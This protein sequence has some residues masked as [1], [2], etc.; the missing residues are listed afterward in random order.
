M[1]LID[2]AVSLHNKQR[3]LGE[4]LLAEGLLNE[5][6][7]HEAIEY[8][9]IY[10]GKLG[11]SLIEL[12]LVDEEQMARV[13]SQQLNL[14]FI[15]PHFLMNVRSD[16]LALVSEKIALKHHIVP[17]HQDGKKLFSALYDATNLQ[18]IDELSF[19]LNHIIVPLAIPEIRL[20][21]ALKKYYGL[22]LTPRY[23][24]LAVQLNRRE[25]AT[26]KSIGK[27]KPQV[28][29]A[30]ATESQPLQEPRPSD[31]TGDASQW[32]LLGDQE[33]PEGAASG[34]YPGAVET[35]ES[36]HKAPD[37][38][39][40]LAN[41]KNRNDIAGALI[42]ALQV[43]F[44]HC[45]LVMVRKETIS[46]WM[47][48]GNKPREQFE[49]LS[50]PGHAESIFNQVVNTD[51][52]VLGPLSDSEHDRRILQ[53]FDSTLP[54]T[55]FAV[56]LR[57]QQRLVSILYIQGPAEQLSRHLNDIHRLTEKAELAFKLLII[58]NKIL[59]T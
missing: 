9:C 41:S 16:T 58:R 35:A 8:Q 15:K 57:V 27:E 3:R 54:Q 30:A 14:H 11:T 48:S 56:P 52:E 55:A 13:L 44:P 10:G 36:T 12:G 2:P 18:L 40:Q 7:L 42:T 22:R 23:E 33:F 31:E 24:T 37:I 38:R 39:L 26:R 59:T 1:A 17:Y 19:Q 47:A 49:Q 53:F 4:H 34:T 50:F 43:T 25:Q 5:E 21:L 45:G 20:M 28:V 29:I 51:A 46:G 32:P 6:Q